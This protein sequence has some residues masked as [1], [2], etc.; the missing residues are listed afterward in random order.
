[1]QSPNPTPSVQ[2]P[3]F[4]G[5]PFHLSLP[6]NVRRNNSITN[7]N[8]SGQA[9]AV[10]PASANSPAP[11]THGTND[12]TDA[13]REGKQRA[14]DVMA[15]SGIDIPSAP[16]A[17]SNEGQANGVEMSRKRSRSGSRL[18]TRTPSAQAT[19]NTDFPPHDQYLLHR[20]MD[21]D[22]QHA[23]IINDQAD[24]HRALMRAKEE[25]LQW[26]R[27]EG[28]AVRQANP[29]AVFGYGYNGYGNGRTD[30]RT[31]ITYP[32]QRKKPG[33]KRVRDLRIPRQDM[34]Q[35][36]EY[37]EELIPVRLDVEMDKL[38]LRDT[39]TWNMND[40]TVPMQLFVET[41]VEDLK[42][43]TENQQ[44]VA[45]EV[46]REIFEQ[47][48]NYFPHVWPVGVP[49]EPDLPYGR[50]KND[51]MRITIKLN[52]TI[53]SITLVDQFEWDINNPMNSPE[54]F[55][56]QM[57]LDL[58]L[59]GEFTTA[60]AHSIREQSQ[61]YTRSL[62][63][64]N[65]EFDGRPVED[66]DIRDNLLPTPVPAVFRPNQSQKD[67]T[68]YLYELSEAE[69]EKT[70]LSML[71]EQRAQKRQLNR[72]GGPALPDLKERPRT[73]RS[74]VVSSVIPGAA[75]T[76]EA[77]G[78]F[79]LKR[80][81]SGKGRRSRFDEGSDSDDLEGESSGPDSPA[82]STINV[83]T[84]ARTRGMRGAATAA[85]AAMR[86]NY[87]RSVTPD[88]AQLQE[89]R[90]SARRSGA[91]EMRE[92]SVAEPTS[93]IV[94]LRIS[95]QKFRAWMAKR[96]LGRTP[97][98]PLSGFPTSQTMPSKAPT[99]QPASMPP[100]STPALK[101]E[102][103]PPSSVGRTVTPQPAVKQEEKSSSSKQYQYNDQGRVDVP[104][105]PAPDDA[106]VSIHTSPPRL[107]PQIRRN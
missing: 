10:Q 16:A 14:K 68:P 1:M 11:P 55:A 51:D 35:Q 47:V 39:F 64:T 46:H 60:I 91:H 23:V 77:S 82:P 80:S 27:T 106:P 12:A 6:P 41:L 73:V 21:R 43:P 52:I 76:L 63:L 75:E 24:R 89:P 71:R 30:G 84:T 44:L 57:A 99:P 28:R 8:S 81:A 66:P 92:E 25:E 50:Y 103:L 87:G 15:A 5:Q 62:F 56:R 74:L 54:E 40:R 7:N 18:P 42:I 85:Q 33:N 69:L 3:G 37:L 96:K 59:S 70:E 20:Y 65:Y 13:I 38:R 4:N 2:S 61:L 32:Q 98:A 95:P 29:G 104:T 94:K 101:H 102:S 79:K 19:S 36:A 67:W 72:R 78:I 45:R 17:N 31:I 86:M 22:S 58:S 105:A 97:A 34:Q 48:Q 53:G 90:S 107:Q 100:P 9:G 26:Y 83:G 49:A 93:L 88:I